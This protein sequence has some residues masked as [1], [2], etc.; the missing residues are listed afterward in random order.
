[1]TLKVQ[2]SIQY[3]P[4]LS[5]C[6]GASHQFGH[7]NFT[8]TLG[9]FPNNQC[10]P[11]KSPSAVPADRWFSLTTPRAGG[12]TPLGLLQLCFQII[13]HFL[14]ILWGLSSFRAVLQ[15]LLTPRNN[16]A[17]V[18]LGAL[19]SRAFTSWQHPLPSFLTYRVCHRSIIHFQ[20]AVLWTMSQVQFTILWT[21]CCA[22]KKELGLWIQ[23]L[24]F[25]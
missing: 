10:F 13:L 6:A 7:T 5:W 4:F 21:R 17:Q 11:N 14:P 19:V 8:L 1:M 2:Y 12:V 18:P 23:W 3:F 25:N 20:S 9:F 16:S 22:Q 24:G 15:S